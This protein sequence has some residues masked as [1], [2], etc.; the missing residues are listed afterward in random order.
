MHTIAMETKMSYEEIWQ[1][2]SRMEKYGGSFVVALANAFKFADP[3]NREKLLNA[4]PEYVNEY[5]P[6]SSL[7]LN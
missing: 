1:M 2:I 4:F 3:S 5:G 7:S 6:N